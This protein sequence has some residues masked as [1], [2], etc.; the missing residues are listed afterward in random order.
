MPPKSKT[1]PTNWVYLGREAALVLLWA[2]VIL[3]AGGVSGL[4]DYGVKAVS[5]GVGVVVL[6]GWLVVRLWRRARLPRSGIEW[7]LAIFIL[8]QLLAVAFSQDPRRS[9]PEV[10]AYVV[11]ALVFYLVLDLLASG[12]PM[13]LFEKTLLIVGGVAV[14][15]ALLALAQSVLAWRALAAG[16]A[17]PPSYQQRLYAVLGDANL[18]SVFVNLLIPLALGRLLLSRGWLARLLL[19]GLVL[20]GLVIDYF[21]SSRGG[22]LGLIAAL[23]TLALL[24]VGF[25]S[26]KAR[27]IA[28][29]VWRGLRARPVVL[30]LLILLALAP[31]AWVG[32]KALRFE[33]DA[34]HSPIFESRTVF[35]EPAWEAL[36]DD[37]LT[38][39]GPA[40]YPSVWMR[41]RSIPPSRPY[42]HAHSTPVT[43]TAE[44]GLIGLAGLV[45]LLVAA[46]RRALPVQSEMETDERTRWA[47]IAATLVG[48]GVHSLFDHFL[49]YASIGIILAVLLAQLFALSRRDE[50]ERTA[51]TSFHPAWLLG[52]GII[53]VLFSAFS[54]RAQA[55]NQRGVSLA[56]DGEWLAAAQAFDRAA[57]DDP[58]VALYW[59]NAAYAYGRAAY[60][61]E[62]DLL[63]LAIARYEQGIALEPDYALNYADL[64]A[65]YRQAGDSQGALEN[66]SKA[67]ELSP[68]AALFWLNLGL[69]YEDQGSLDLAQQAYS[70]ALDIDPDSAAA[71]FWTGTDLRQET[72]A[73]W[74]EA[75]PAEVSTGEVDTLIAQG[76]HA[77]QAGD[78]DAAEGALA[79]AWRLDD[80]GVSLYQGL[81]ELAVAKGEFESA[82]RYLLLSLGMQTQTNQGKVW[83]LLA[84]AELAHEHGDPQVALA[85]YEQVYNAVSEYTV[86]GWGT[87]GWN[88][89]AWFVH[90][91][92]GLPVDVLPQLER[93]DLTPELAARLLPLV[94]LY[95]G[96]G[97]QASAAAVRQRLAPALP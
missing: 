25:V 97:D 76:R 65:L 63:E 48:F 10:L 81:A 60:D 45:V 43:L 95:E 47:A 23:G 72:L 40:T 9:L 66:L 58:T 61:G 57:E 69:E 38:G 90:R 50:T 2:Y 3:V 21:A 59:L 73:A 77:V 68:D 54:L 32:V 84:R 1:T 92:P 8:T 93:L 36:K 41:A 39:V 18:L 7:A 34:T 88:P 37:P 44:S 85:L 19:G 16:L 31:V 62:G 35:W 24:W 11:Y 86:H 74:Q 80:Q 79:E 30:A 91:R 83:S 5:L 53:V 70:R 78:L 71:V 28:E 75:Q 52:I 13:E 55:H 17:Y 33:G 49:S 89:Y 42:Q 46:V 20:G 22:T 27:R 67:T 26:A 14:G 51:R 12:W 87:W 56:E 96:Q 29:Q 15:L 4:V 64:G 82:D 6:G 94:E